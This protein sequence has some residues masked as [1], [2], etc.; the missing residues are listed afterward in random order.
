MS[1]IREAIAKAK[2]TRESGGTSDSD[3]Q[4]LGRLER[5]GMPRVHDPLSP[6][7]SGAARAETEVPVV[8]EAVPSR[9]ARSAAPHAWHA[10]LSA[11]GRILHV[12]RAA[13]RE[14]GLLAPQSQ[15]R[16][17]AEEYRQIKRPLLANADGRS[18]LEVPDAT[19]IMVTSA[20]PND[21]KTFTCINL[22][23]SMAR[24]KDHHVVLV[25]GDVANPELSRLFGVQGE[26]G[27]LD[28]LRNTDMRLE[29]CV[30][31]TDVPGLS[32]LPAGQRDEDATELLASQRMELLMDSLKAIDPP[33]IALFDSAPLLMATESVALAAHVGQ[34]VVVVKE[35]RTTQQQVQRAVEILDPDKALSL[36]LNQVES[37]G[38]WLA[39]GATYGQYGYGQDARPTETGAKHH[40]GD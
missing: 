5:S 25:D 20:V 16:R 24:E 18:G 2:R 21:G 34:I 4:R 35:G 13:L 9:G 6:E 28:F 11:S 19:L 23:L 40:S 17:L 7:R 22:S 8:D 33:P 36:I 26:P 39:Y 10:A 1:K 27:L 12:D 30:V 3:P 38:D 32:L 31:A 37:T 29:D 14:A 15:E